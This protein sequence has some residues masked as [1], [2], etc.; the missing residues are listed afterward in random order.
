MRDI[1]LMS[2]ILAAFSAITCLALSGKYSLFAIV[3]IVIILII[4]L[5]ALILINVVIRFA[6]TATFDFQLNGRP[7]GFHIHNIPNPN[8]QQNSW[9]GWST[10]PGGWTHHNL[11]NGDTLTVE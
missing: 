10:T 7:F 1:I 4:S 9:G 5:S 11:D 2:P 8:T 6:Q 3:A